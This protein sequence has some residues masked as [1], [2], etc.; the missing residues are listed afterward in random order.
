[1]KHRSDKTHLLRAKVGPMV[2]QVAWY[3]GESPKWL[4]IACET[5]NRTVPPRHLPIPKYARLVRGAIDCMACIAL[6]CSS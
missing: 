5:A 4:T 3:F 1:M 2:H 6:G